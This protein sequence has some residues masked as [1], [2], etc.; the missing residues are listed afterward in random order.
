M[1]GI[2]PF[3]WFDD[4]AE[5]AAKQYVSIFSDVGRG[6]S[7]ITDVTRYPEA[8]AQVSG[9]PEGSVM[10][11]AFRL[12]GQDFVALNGGP[13]FRFTEAISFVV[14]CETQDEVDRLWERLSEGGEEGPCGWLKDRYGVS[15]QVV[16]TALAQMLADEDPSRRARVT[17]AMLQMKKLDVDALQRAAE[18]A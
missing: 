18:R 13:E 12:D 8:A 7:R 4:Q 11:V 1:K 9:R 2:T 17:A 14:N 10:T 3:L 5:E 16:P 15:W 6:E